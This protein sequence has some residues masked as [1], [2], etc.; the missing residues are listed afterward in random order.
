MIADP[1]PKYLN[2]V[3]NTDQAAGVLLASEA[4]ADRLGVPEEKRVRWWGG[5]QA[6]ER[7][8]WVSERGELG[9]APAMRACAERLFQAAGIGIGDVQHLDFY[10]CFPVAVELACEAF[11]VAQDDPRG[12]TTTGG[13]PYHGGPVN[14]YTIHG[15]VTVAERCRAEPG[16]VGL[17]TG[18]GWYLTKHSASAWSTRPKP[19]EAPAFLGPDD[20]SAG[21]DPIPVVERPEGVGRVEAYTVIYGRDGEPEYGVVLGRLEEG[22]GRFIANLSGDAGALAAFAAQDALGRRGR[23][24]A[25]DER[26]LFHPV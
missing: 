15:L 2:S 17:A 9:D 4:A 16:S 12:L 5:A 13:L 6:N 8:W 22:G 11:G 1:Y 26:N 19:G 25:G 7:A 21:P 14:N 10:S 18:N 24:Q 3:L 23:V 20:L